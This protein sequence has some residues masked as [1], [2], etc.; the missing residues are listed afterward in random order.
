[1][2]LLVLSPPR[3]VH[4]L[5]SIVPFFLAW[6]K[7]IF[8]VLFFL[9]IFCYSLGF[10]ISDYTTALIILDTTVEITE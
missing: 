9:S 6:R 2:P 3:Y 4:C 10:Q 1:M 7:R 5:S 8:V